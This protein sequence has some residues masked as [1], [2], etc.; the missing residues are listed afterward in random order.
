MG[1]WDFFLFSLPDVEKSFD[2]C[3]FMY[4]L[5]LQ[6]SACLFSSIKILLFS[7]YIN[8]VLNK[9]ASICSSP[10]CFSGYD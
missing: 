6:P 3:L 7:V 4:L 5:V 9:E 8:A 2:L 10:V 1:I